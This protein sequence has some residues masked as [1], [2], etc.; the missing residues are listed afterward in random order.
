MDARKMT[1]LVEVS[2]RGISYTVDRDDIVLDVVEVHHDPATGEEAQTAD[3]WGA[4]VSV[5]HAQVAVDWLRVAEVLAA[6][7]AMADAAQIR[8]SRNAESMD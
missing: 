1:L 2:D 5:R 6:A 4:T 8:A 3:V 7:P